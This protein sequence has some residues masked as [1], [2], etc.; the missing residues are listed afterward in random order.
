VADQQKPH[1]PS[2]ASEDD[3]VAAAFAS[4]RTAAPQNFTPLPSTAL[5]T[6]AGATANRPR[7]RALTISLAAV[8]CTA[9][10]AAGVAVA[11][12]VVSGPAGPSN[13]DGSKSAEGSQGDGTAEDSAAGDDASSSAGTS[14]EPVEE[15]LQT[16]VVSLPNWPGDLSADC[17]AGDYSFNPSGGSDTE[18]SGQKPAGSKPGAWQLLP[19]GAPAVSTQLDGAGDSEVIAPVACGDVAGVVALARNTDGFVTVGFVHAASSPVGPITVAEVDGGMVTLSF[20]DSQGVAAEKRQY[21]YTGSEFTEVKPGEEPTTQP[22]TLPTE[23]SPSSPSDGEDSSPDKTSDPHGDPTSSGA[24]Q[25][26]DTARVP[27][28][29]TPQGG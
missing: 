23:E 7:K 19:G 24:Q 18:D 4:Y 28:V 21:N 10:M 14:G 13:A 1:T 8:A 5:L 26:G 3:I 20:A 25:D 17:P 12:T 2:A 11:Q 9:L 16:L 27:A 22:S 29:N 15:E 6:R